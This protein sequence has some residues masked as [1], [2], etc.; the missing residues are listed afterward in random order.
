LFLIKTIL[1]EENKMINNELLRKAESGNTEAMRKVAMEYLQEQDLDNAIKW[2][3]EAAELGDVEAMADMAD[4]YRKALKHDKAFEWEEKAAN[5]GRVQSMYNLSVCYRDGLGTAVN[6]EQHTYWY[7]KAISEGFKDIVAEEYF[8]DLEGTDVSYEHYK[9]KLKTSLTILKVFSIIGTIAGLVYGIF[10]MFIYDIFEEGLA[11][12]I[13]GVFICA[14]IGLLIGF[15]LPSLPAALKWGWGKSKPMLLFFFPFNE[16]S[17]SGFVQIRFVVGLA[18]FPFLLI[19]LV[20][21]FYASPI[22]GIYRFFSIKREL[23]E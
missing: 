2:T 22:V 11:L 17:D 5:Q 4:V 15:A 14:V 23:K 20:L 7:E 19:P 10:M 18:L 12:Q 1:Q 16:N 13:L 6:K 9:R 8:Y 3:G 21:A